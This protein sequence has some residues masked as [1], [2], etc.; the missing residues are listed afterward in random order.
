MK[1]VCSLPGCD[2]ELLGTAVMLADDTDYGI[3]WEA[4]GYETYQHLSAPT[5][6]IVMHPTCFLALFDEL[7]RAEAQTVLRFILGNVGELKGALAEV[8]T[9]G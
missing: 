3:D 8:E 2:E 4:G 9:G 1:I 7:L 5:P 6:L